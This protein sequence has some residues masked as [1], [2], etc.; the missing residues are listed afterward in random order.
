MSEPEMERSHKIH[1]RR[2]SKGTGS[3]L[4]GVGNDLESTTLHRRGTSFLEIWGGVGKCVCIQTKWS[5]LG[6]RSRK[7]TTIQHQILKNSMNSEIWIFT[8]FEILFLVSKISPH[9]FCY[10]VVK[11]M[12]SW[13]RPFQ[14]THATEC[15]F[16][17][18][19]T[20]TV[21]LLYST[22]R[23]LL[24]KKLCWCHSKRGLEF[25]CNWKKSIPVSASLFKDTAAVVPCGSY[26]LNS[27]LN[28]GMAVQQ[29]VHQV[30]FPSASLE[31]ALID[32]ANNSVSVL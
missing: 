26:Q 13:T 7:N 5:D 6:R 31:P 22:D 2:N 9:Y 17:F 8:T 1:E 21:I 28:L 12:H 25:S 32:H 15:G 11:S 14:V 18:M 10:Y 23:H 3:S 29:Q 19:S 30:T 27:T 16:A 4:D 20:H 24:P